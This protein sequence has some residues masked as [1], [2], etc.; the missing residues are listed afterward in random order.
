MNTFLTLHCSSLHLDQEFRTICFVCPWFLREQSKDIQAW[1]YFKHLEQIRHYEHLKCER[2][3]RIKRQELWF[4]M[5]KEQE[6]V[7]KNLINSHSMEE[8]P[9][10]E[11]IVVSD[12][13][14]LVGDEEKILRI[15]T[16]NS[17]S[18]PRGFYERLLIV[19]HSL[20]D[21]RLDYANITIGRTVEKNLL[22]IER[23]E[24]DQNITITTNSSLIESI[25]NLL[26]SRL[27]SFYPMMKFRIET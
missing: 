14:I 21:E 22:Q 5:E 10:I 24:I 7:V 19:L 3:R 27:F 16:E 6:F 12:A 25:E 4:D 8:L 2:T 23:N 20:F 26:H 1:E 11:Q 17:S 13:Q 18:L 15:S 9:S